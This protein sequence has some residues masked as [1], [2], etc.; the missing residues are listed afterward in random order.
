MNLDCI[1]LHIDE[2]SSQFLDIKRKYGPKVNIHDPGYLGCLLLSSE[3]EEVTAA[4]IVKE[5]GLE[6][7]DDYFCRSEQARQLPGRME[8]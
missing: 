1:V 3:C 2:N 5:F 8:S 7:M 6:P 4:D